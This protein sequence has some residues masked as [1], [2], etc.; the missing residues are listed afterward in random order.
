MGGLLAHLRDQIAP[1]GLGG[2]RLAAVFLPGFR[3]MAGQAKRLESV[4]VEGGLGR[5]GAVAG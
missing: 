5:A 4:R 1:C 3:D 2:R